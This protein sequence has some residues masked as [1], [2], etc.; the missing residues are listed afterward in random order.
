MYVCEE[1]HTVDAVPIGC[2]MSFMEHGIF[3]GVEIGQ[4]EVC[5]KEEVN[6]VFCDEYQA[7]III[8][9]NKNKSKR[10]EVMK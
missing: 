9:G 6:C 10:N 1:C 8:R 2:D 5:G 7:E 4:C 3:T